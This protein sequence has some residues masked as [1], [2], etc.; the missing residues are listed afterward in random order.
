MEYS[1]EGCNRAYTLDLR[2]S[3][4]TT[5]N[6]VVTKLLSRIRLSLSVIRFQNGRK[7]SE[8]VLFKFNPYLHD[9]RTSQFNSF[10]WNSGNILS[11]ELGCL[12]CIINIVVFTNIVVADARDT[13]LY[14]NNLYFTKLHERCP[15]VIN[16]ILQ[17]ALFT[18]YVIHAT[19]TYVRV[20][21]CF[22][23]VFTLTVLFL[24]HKF[25]R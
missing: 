8:G 3:G 25:T 10:G 2:R 15:S 12:F 23:D 11:W 1:L 22:L 5:C 9:F 6:K 21:V 7:K 24:I 17:N 19:Y 20:Y 16:N 18:L 14:Y 4:I 13:Y